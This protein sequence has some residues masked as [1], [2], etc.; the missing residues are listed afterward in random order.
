MLPSF[1][2]ISPSLLR[3]P[4]SLLSWLLALHSSG[5]LKAHVHA[6]LGFVNFLTS[7]FVGEEWWKR[8]EFTWKRGKRNARSFFKCIHSC[9]L[10]SQVS[11]GRLSKHLAQELGWKTQLCNKCLAISC[12]HTHQLAYYFA[13]WLHAIGLKL[14]LQ[15]CLWTRTTRNSIFIQFPQMGRK[16]QENPLRKKGRP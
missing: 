11:T 10:C 1:S 6:D 9:T 14:N 12:L 3:W 8:N 5:D 13:R 2:P 16:K 15:G 7:W 4:V